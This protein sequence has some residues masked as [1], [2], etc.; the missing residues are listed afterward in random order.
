L[1]AISESVD[2]YGDPKEPLLAP[3]ALRDLVTKAKAGDEMAKQRVILANVGLARQAAFKYYRELSNP[4]LDVRDLFQEALI[5][6]NRAVEL[7]DPDRGYTFSTY[8]HNWIQQ[9][10]VGYL[11]K[12]SGTLTTPECA[13]GT[14]L[15]EAIRSEFESRN[16]RE[17]TPDEICKIGRFSMSSLER[18]LSPEVYVTSYHQMTARASSTGDDLENEMIDILAPAQ[19]DLAE[20]VGQNIDLRRALA[21]LNLSEMELSIVEMNFGF[22]V[23]V[24]MSV[25]AIAKQVGKK[26]KEVSDILEDVISRL[27]DSLHLDEYASI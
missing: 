6:I 18:Y 20:D 17:P 13:H 8:A 15:V 27:R 25:N 2:L 12:N 11:R 19:S 23:Y 21:G 5:G 24:P 22:G 9:A 7:F 4:N 1:T 3:D 26:T 14:R 10:I 16:G